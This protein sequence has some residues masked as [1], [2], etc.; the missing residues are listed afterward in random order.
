[1]ENNRIFL[2]D[3]TSITIFINNSS[4]E[5]KIRNSYLNFWSLQHF[6]PELVFTVLTLQIL[7][8]LYEIDIHGHLFIL[9]LPTSIDLWNLQDLIL[10]GNW[11]LSSLFGCWGKC[12]NAYNL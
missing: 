3:Y 4:I 8:R 9:D 6:I 12:G 5:S 11:V 7:Y 10:A 2:L 1:L